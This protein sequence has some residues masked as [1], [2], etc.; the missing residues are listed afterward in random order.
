M[1]S[2]E[3]YILLS[4]LFQVQYEVQFPQLQFSLRCKNRKLVGDSYNMLDM[5][6]EINEMWV[7][8]IVINIYN[9]SIDK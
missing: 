8:H 5:V 3:L 9:D 6:Y 4:S 2:E 1:L 7:S